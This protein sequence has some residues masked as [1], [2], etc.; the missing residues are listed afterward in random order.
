MLTNLQNSFTGGLSDK[1]AINSYLNIT[2]HLNY[3]A[4]LPCVTS[5]FKNR[6]AQE[7]IEANCHVTLSHSKNSF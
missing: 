3:V 4:A 5:I 7:V 2:L 1:F 6:H